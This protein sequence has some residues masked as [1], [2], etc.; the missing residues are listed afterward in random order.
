MTSTWTSRWVAES[1]TVLGKFLAGGSHTW[2]IDARNG[3]GITTVVGKTA[4]F[5]GGSG[6]SEFGGTAADLFTDGE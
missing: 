5:A 6:S 2:R 4:I 1:H 3:F